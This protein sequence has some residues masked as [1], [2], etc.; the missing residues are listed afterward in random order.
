MSSKLLKII[1]TYICSPDIEAY[2]DKYFISFIDDYL[3]Y[4]YIYL[5]NDK[6]EA[7]DAFKKS[8]KLK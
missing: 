7:L 1:H 6:K 4:I 2:H 5:H 8:L 3:W